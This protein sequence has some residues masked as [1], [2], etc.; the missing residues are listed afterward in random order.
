MGDNFES[1]LQLLHLYFTSPRKDADVWKT[2]I[3]Q[4]QSALTRNAN[5]PGGV[6][7]DTVIAVLGNYSPR[8][9]PPTTEKLNAASLDKGYAFY[10]A[11]FADASNFTFTFT[12]DFTVD[13]IV[14]YL[15]TYLGSLPST[16]SKETF[17]NLGIHP[18]AGQVTKTIYKGASNKATVQLIFSGD[19]NYNDAN[20]TQI[21]ALEEILNIRLVDS[22]KEGNGIYSPGVRVNYA[23]NPEGRYKVTI[24]FLTDVNTVD[25]ATA[26]ILSEINR[27]KLNGADDNDVKL[28]I[29]RQ[30]R[31]IQSQYKQNT[32]WQATLTTSA[33][34]QENQ[35]KIL[36]R[37]Q[38]LE[39]VTKQST[40]DATIRYLGGNNLIKIILLPEK[41]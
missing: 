12:G 3:S 19:Y 20:N 25:K 8:S 6:Y 33:Q 37:V 34:N 13:A 10:K 26:Y 40:K 39:Q 24:S 9:M 1:A 28:F 35:D 18:P 27:L 32:F 7:Q 23:K 36:S 21:D 29:A 5:A 41:K 31:T 17:K 2:Y 30:A 16:N 38:D 4:A 22:L 14:P 11:R 15:A